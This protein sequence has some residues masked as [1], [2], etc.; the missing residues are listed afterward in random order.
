MDGQRR[1]RLVKATHAG[2][3]HQ[4]LDAELGDLV[5]QFCECI[6]I[7]VLNPHSQRRLGGLGRERHAPPVF[8]IGRVDQRRAPLRSSQPRLE[9]RRVVGHQDQQLLGAVANGFDRRAVGLRVAGGI[10]H[11]EAVDAQGHADVVH[12]IGVDRSDDLL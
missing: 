4:V 7:G 6:E 8:G 2:I 9:R 3:E 12:G 1:Q 10:G 11:G 5:G